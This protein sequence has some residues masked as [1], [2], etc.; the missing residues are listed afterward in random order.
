M[1]TAVHVIP[2]TII[3][4]EEATEETTPPQTDRDIMERKTV[5][6]GITIQTG[7]AKVQGIIVP[8]EVSKG[9]EAQA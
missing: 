9:L 1:V 2:G 3:L 5:L 7:Q 8:T 4:G 6:S